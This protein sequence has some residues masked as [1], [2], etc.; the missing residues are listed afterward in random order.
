MSTSWVFLRPALTCSAA[1]IHAVFSL[2]WPCEGSPSCSIKNPI[3]ASV[4]VPVSPCR[5][6]SYASLVQHNS[7]SVPYGGGANIRV[8]PPRPASYT[9]HPRSVP[10]PAETSAGAPAHILTAADTFVAEPPVPPPPTAGAPGDIALSLIQVRPI[11]SES[12]V[13]QVH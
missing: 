11:A 3:L 5:S 13:V 12:L 1:A 8:A 4:H 6:F 7:T 9:G 2:D 10:V